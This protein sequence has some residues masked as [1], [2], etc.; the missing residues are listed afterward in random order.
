[1]IGSDKLLVGN[2][3]PLGKDRYS[4]KVVGRELSVKTQSVRIGSIVEFEEKHIFS[5]S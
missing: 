4:G 2:I 3:Q 1:M 5:F